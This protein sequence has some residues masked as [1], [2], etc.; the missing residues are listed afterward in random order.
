[1]VR[2]SIDLPFSGLRVIDLSQI[3]NGPY[4]TYLMALEGAEL[5]KVEPPAGE[6]LRKR[7]VVGGAGLPFAMLNG[8]K[9]S[10]ALDLKT[11]EGKQ[12]LLELADHA[13][14]LVENF[15]PGVMDRLGLGAEVLQGRNPRLIYAASSGYGRD[16]PY[17]SYPAMDLRARAHA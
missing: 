6:P 1:M 7:T 2:N 11:E 5:I 16:G 12:A 15:S 9:R 14:V 4:A 13:D 10:I 3:Y 17:K 8:A